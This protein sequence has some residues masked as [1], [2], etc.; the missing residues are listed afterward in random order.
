MPLSA[1]TASAATYPG[2]AVGTYKDMNQTMFESK[3][4][5][6]NYV[7]LFIRQ[8]MRHMMPNTLKIATLGQKAKGKGVG[9]ILTAKSVKQTVF[10]MLKSNSY[11][12]DYPIYLRYTTS[13]ATDADLSSFNTFFN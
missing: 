9:V 5:N 13:T 3:I 7:L 2:I 8:R 1:I 12:F 4:A 6:Y 10:D 11:K